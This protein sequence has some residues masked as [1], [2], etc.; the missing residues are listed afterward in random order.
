MNP[1]SSPKTIFAYAKSN[2]A[3]WYWIT[4]STALL[5]ATLA[6]ATPEDPFPLSLVRYTFESIFILW[7]PGYVFLRILYP[8]IESTAQRIA[9]SIGLSLVLVPLIGLLLNY[10]DWGIR[11]IPLTISLLA[12]VLIM[13]TAAFV[14]DLAAETTHRKDVSTPLFS[15]K[16]SHE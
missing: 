10:T 8:K 12:F 4:I 5:A 6:L 9:F 13:A 16:E 3:W 14:R 11:R 2:R 1:F 15:K 7:L